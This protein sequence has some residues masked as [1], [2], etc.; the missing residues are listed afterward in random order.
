MAVLRSCIPPFSIDLDIKSSGWYLLR[1]QIM[2]ASTY[3]FSRDDDPKERM[4]GKVARER[5]KA[6]VL[7]TNPNLLISL[8]DY[9]ISGGFCDAQGLKCHQ[10]IR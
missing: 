9:E 8:I 6:F 1:T 5:R 7:C 2:R 4:P 3:I 10:T